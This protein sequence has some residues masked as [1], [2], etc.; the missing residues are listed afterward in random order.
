MISHKTKNNSARHS[1]FSPNINNTLVHI[2]LK[3]KND[4]TTFGLNVEF[5]NNIAIIISFL[6]S[7]HLI[8]FRIL[9]IKT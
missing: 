1:K 8:I 4:L 7:F 9:D 5:I 6:R 2:L 3:L